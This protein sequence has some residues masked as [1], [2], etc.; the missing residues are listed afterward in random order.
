M[1]QLIAFLLVS[2][3]L[4]AQSLTA[5]LSSTTVAP[6][7][8]TTLTWGWSG[9]SLAAV[10]ASIQTTGGSISSPA[11]SVRT[12]LA[13]KSVACSGPAPATWACLLAGIVTSPPPSWIV[14]AGS[15]AAGPEHSMITPGPLASFTITAPPTVGTYS[16]TLANGVGSDAT[17][18]G[19]VLAPASVSF[20]VGS[21]TPPPSGPVTDLNGDGKTDITDERVEAD[22]VLK[23]ILNQVAPALGAPCPN[24][25][26]QVGCTI[27]DYMLV[28]KAAGN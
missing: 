8:T 25:A 11:I 3:A 21:G 13:V 4:H 15:S 16:I 10:Q 17:G 23:A 18:T 6:G 27:A 5:S 22:N 2:L 1:K 12:G 9:P 7:G 14:S 19:T 26:A 24:S 28:V 20:T